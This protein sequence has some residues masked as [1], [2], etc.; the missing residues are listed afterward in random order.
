LDQCIVAGDEEVTST[1]LRA[2]HLK[3]IPWLSLRSSM[4]LRA[5]AKI[6]GDAMKAIQFLI[7]NQFKD[8]TPCWSGNA[9]TV[10]V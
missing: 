2:R 1:V 6:C 7:E 10:G 5:K 4:S 8:K 9:P 3:R